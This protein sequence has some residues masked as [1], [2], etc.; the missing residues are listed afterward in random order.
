[1]HRS[2]GGTKVDSHYAF[3]YNFCAIGI[4][5]EQMPSSYSTTALDTT[6]YL[7]NDNL[8]VIVIIV[9]A[10]MGFSL[11]IIGLLI[12]VLFKKKVIALLPMDKNKNKKTP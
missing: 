7:P 6:D 12:I 1:M 8:S 9:A 3:H 4:T 5:G 2:T 11:L 10:C